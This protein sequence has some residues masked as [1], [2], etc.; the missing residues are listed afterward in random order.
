MLISSKGMDG[1]GLIIPYKNWYHDAKVTTGT[2]DG[3]VTQ[4]LVWLRSR[5]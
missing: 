4:R 2:D 3:F 1:L 5:T